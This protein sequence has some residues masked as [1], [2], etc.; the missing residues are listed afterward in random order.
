MKEK[1]KTLALER[2]L[3]IVKLTKKTLYETIFYC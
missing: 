2:V 3:A 1:K